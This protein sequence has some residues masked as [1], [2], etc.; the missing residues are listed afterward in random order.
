LLPVRVELDRRRVDGRASFLQHAGEGLFQRL[1]N[2][3][4]ITLGEV[5][6]PPGAYREAAK[7]YYLLGDTY[8]AHSGIARTDD[9]K[10]AGLSMAAIMTVAPFQVPVGT[11]VTNRYVPHMNELYAEAVACSITN[12]DAFFARHFESKLHFYNSLRLL[13]TF[14]GLK[15]FL[16]DLEEGTT[17][18][19][20]DVAF[21]RYDHARVSQAIQTGEVIMNFKVFA[22]PPSVHPA[23]VQPDPDIPT[24]T[25]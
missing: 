14:D 2:A 17:K 24:A 19:A 15:E 11:S 5:I 25:K 18:D 20:Y 8:K 21:S 10:K 7:A 3:K 9:I 6:V 16:A 23:P 12:N 13:A 22:Q 1:L 4:R